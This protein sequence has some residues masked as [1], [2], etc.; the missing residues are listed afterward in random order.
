MQLG[1]KAPQLLD[2]VREGVVDIVWTLPGF[3]AGRMPKVEVFELPFVHKSAISSTLALQDYQA[4]YLGEEL[5]EFKPLLLHSHEGTLFMTKKPVTSVA[6][7]KTMKMR[8]A[9]RTGVWFLQSLGSDAIGAPL[10]RIPPMLS[11]GTINGVMLPYEIAPAVKMHEL[12]SYFT[13]LSRT[14]TEDG[15][16]RVHLLD[17]QG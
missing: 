14:D 17:E 8:A 11:K 9:N 3:T 7:F 6:D 15:N 13:D 10:G 16:G 5:K 1:G 2:Q 4:K 12:V